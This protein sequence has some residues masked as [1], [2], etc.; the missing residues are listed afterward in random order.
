MT[1]TIQQL[2]DRI[3]SVI[4]SGAQPLHAPVSSVGSSKHVLSALEK[5]LVSVDPGI[6]S[7]AED[8]LNDIAGTRRCVLVSSGTSA[9]HLALLSLGVKEGD[10]VLCPSVSFVATA[11][12]VLYCGAKPYFVDVDED[13][14]GMSPYFLEEA[15]ARIETNQ[16]SSDNKPARKPAAILVV[17]V[18]GLSPKLR[19]LQRVSSKHGIPILIDAAGALG[20]ELSGKSVFRYGTVAITSFN[21]N[22]IVSS[23]SG[24]AIFSDNAKILDKCEHLSRVAKV[25]HSYEFIHDS[26]GYNYRLPAL[27]AAMLLD[28]LE[29]FDDI[30]SRKRE[31]HNRY[32]TA[33]EGTEFRLISEGANSSSNYWLNSIDCESSGITSKDACDFLIDSGIGCRPLWTPLPLLQHLRR[34]SGAQNSAI[35][36]KLHRSTLSLP[37]S[38]SIVDE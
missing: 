38:Y 36:R 37:S 6:I 9:L 30:L 11:N 18:F 5:S 7:A 13:D 8:R 26:L 2:E 19:E 10:T 16:N 33:F 14:L 28:Q 4:G 20:T 31:L 3:R 32:S 22:K 21:G 25:Q 34:F 24:G 17:S 15:I 35:A 23:G 12:A 1:T 29:N 27:N